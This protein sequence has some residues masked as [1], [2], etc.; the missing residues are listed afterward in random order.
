MTKVSLLLARF[1]SPSRFSRVLIADTPH[2]L[3][4]FPTTA[5]STS[6]GFRAGGRSRR[7]ISRLFPFRPS[8]RR[9]QDTPVSALLDQSHHAQQSIQSSLGQPKRQLLFAAGRR[10]PL[11]PAG[12]HS[13]SRCRTTLSPSHRPWYLGEAQNTGSDPAGPPARCDDRARRGGSEGRRCR[14]SASM[15]GHGIQVLV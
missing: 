10:R 11:F 2:P 15:N 9:P 14:R 12:R 8:V 4:F 6:R 7:T 13:S 3:A 5:R 1:H